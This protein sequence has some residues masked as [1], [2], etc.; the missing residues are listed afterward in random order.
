MQRP[1][2]MSRVSRCA[3]TVAVL[4][5][6]LLVIGCNR[7]TLLRPDASRGDFERTSREVVISDRSARPDVRGQLGMAQQLLSAGDVAGAEKAARGALKID[8]NSVG[9][10]ALLALISERRGDQREAGIHYQ[11]AIELAPAQGAMHNNYGAW[12]CRNG[13]AGDSLDSFERALADPSYATP[14]TA[15]ANLGA[16]A[17][18]AGDPVRAR[19]ALERALAIDPANAVALGAMAELEFRQGDAFRARAFSE[20]RLAAAPADARALR[21]ASQIEEKLGDT[22]S[23]ESYVRRLR[24]EFPQEP[25]TAGDNRTR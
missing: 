17:D 4:A 21:I 13:R 10:H 14:G 22:R 6:C 20:R 1:E 24:S 25:D 3:G 19:V 11:R 2:P 12:L 15:L 8:S 5:A 23:A 16:C 7:I 9:A 18:T